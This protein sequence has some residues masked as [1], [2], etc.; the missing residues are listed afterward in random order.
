[1]KIVENNLSSKFYACCNVENKNEKLDILRVLV[2]NIDPNAYYVP[3]T[4]TYR[5]ENCVERK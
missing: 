1:M 2:Q 5:K 3:K 4:L